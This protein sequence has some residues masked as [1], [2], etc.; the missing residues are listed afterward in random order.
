MFC[1]ARG[2]EE[3]HAVGKAGE[4]RGSEF[5]MAE[6]TGH[7]PRTGKLASTPVKIGTK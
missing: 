6:P 1:D 2:S 5:I 7:I 3:E 4:D